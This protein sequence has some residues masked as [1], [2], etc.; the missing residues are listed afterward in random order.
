MPLIINAII[1]LQ[2]LTY[3]SKIY[4]EHSQSTLFQNYRTMIAS[5]MDILT[6]IYYKLL[7]W[8]SYLAILCLLLVLEPSLG[9]C[10]LLGWILITLGTHVLLK[11]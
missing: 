3:N 1:G 9:A 11:N 2:Y 8:V 6:V 4:S 7:P 10:I 5:A